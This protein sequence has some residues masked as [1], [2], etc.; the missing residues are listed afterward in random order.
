MRKDLIA[1]LA[2]ELNDK[3]EAALRAAVTE[4]D[5][6]KFVASVIGRL[7]QHQNNAI[8]KLLGLEDRWGKWE[9]DHCNGRSS[10]ITQY[11]SSAVEP[12]VRDWVNQAVRE[13]IE[14]DG[15]VMRTQVLG[16]LRKE[17]EDRYKRE[18]RNSAVNAINT[19]AAEHGKA[20]AAK[21]LAEVTGEEA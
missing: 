20:I 6:D 13:V 14:T 2:A 19:A 4:L 17:I 15:E 11:L 10:P 16:A 9:V 5:T 1:Q 12:T 7:R 21:L 18:L 8:W 3:A